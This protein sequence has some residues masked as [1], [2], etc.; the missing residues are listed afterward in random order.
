M[1]IIRNS[2]RDWKVG[3]L[4]SI[5]QIWRMNLTDK[6]EWVKRSLLSEDT[7]KALRSESSPDGVASVG[8]HWQFFI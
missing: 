2:E 6:G 3:E 1:W 8:P 5:S 4:G 7:E